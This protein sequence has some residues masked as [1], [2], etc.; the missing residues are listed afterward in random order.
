MRWSSPG[1]PCESPCRANRTSGLPMGRSGAMLRAMSDDPLRAK[2]KPPQQAGGIISLAD[3]DQERRHEAARRL[4]ERHNAA[5]RPPA[6]ED[7]A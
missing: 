3:R 4:A 5:L 2:P 1:G 7:A 6:P